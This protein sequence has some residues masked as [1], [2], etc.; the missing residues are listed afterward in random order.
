MLPITIVQW[1]CLRVSLGWGGGMLG[2]E[3][4]MLAWVPIHSGLLGPLTL[5]RLLGVLVEAL[6]LLKPTCVVW[7]V[8]ALLVLMPAWMTMS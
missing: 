1:R 5:V 2:I 6:L 3:S 7:S 8:L 4:R